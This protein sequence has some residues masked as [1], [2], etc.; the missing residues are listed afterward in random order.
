[1]LVWTAVSQYG[2]LG[3]TN[4]TKYG[5]VLI[6]DH[7][8]LAI[9]SWLKVKNSNPLIDQ[10]SYTVCTKSQYWIYTCCEHV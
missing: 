9:I 4:L 8:L 6:N 1:M 5:K 10:D 7:K 2:E 3:L